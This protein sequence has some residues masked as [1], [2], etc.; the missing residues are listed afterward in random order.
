MA[1]AVVIE[2]V[3]SRRLLAFSA[4]I[5]FAPAGAARAPGLQTDY[6]AMYGV[7]RDG[8]SYGLGSQ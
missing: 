7:R 8:L 2:S 3:E 1:K 5:N 4:A 6:G